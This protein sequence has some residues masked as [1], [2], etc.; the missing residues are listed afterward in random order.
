MAKLATQTFTITLSRAVPSDASGGITALNEE[1]IDQ[2][3]EAIVALAND[4][5]IVVDFV[6]AL[7]VGD[8]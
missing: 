6:E 4:D 8:E 1:A 3:K 7:Y 2:L 5:S